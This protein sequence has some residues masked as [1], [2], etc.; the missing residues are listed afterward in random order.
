MTVPHGRWEDDHLRCRPA[1]AARW[2]P[3]V[4]LMDQWANDLLA[5]CKSVSFTRHLKRG[6]MVMMDSLP[7][8]GLPLSAGVIEAASKL[9]YLPSTHRTQPDP[10]GSPSSSGAAAT[11][12]EQAI[13]AS[14]AS[15]RK[16]NDRIQPA[17]CTNY[18]RHTGYASMTGSAL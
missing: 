5:I 12:T 1:Q 2:S 9:R 3:L 11:M 7:V 17:E 4:R 18:F 14:R 13:T 15:W 6:D 10:G 8:T 16:T